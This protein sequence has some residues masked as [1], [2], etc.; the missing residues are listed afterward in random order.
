MSHSNKHSNH[1]AD[2]I[3]IALGTFGTIYTMITLSVLRYNIHENSFLYPAIVFLAAGFILLGGVACGLYYRK[4]TNPTNVKDE[5]I[6]ETIMILG[7]MAYFLFQIFGM[8]GTIA[9]IITY[10][11]TMNTLCIFTCIHLSVGLLVMLFGGYI[12]YNIAKSTQI[13]PG[14]KKN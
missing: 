11:F 12:Y 5:N 1:A 2:N 3:A 14:I 8:M 13:A 7:L 6:P 4:H 10:G 9:S